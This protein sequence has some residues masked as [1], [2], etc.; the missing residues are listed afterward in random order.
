MDSRMILKERI[1]LR[2][3]LAEGPPEHWNDFL[4]ARYQGGKKKVTNTNPKTKDRYKQVTMQ[5]LFNSDEAFKKKV[6]EEYETWVGNGVGKKKNTSKSNAFNTPSVLGTLEELNLFYAEYG[7]LFDEEFNLSG[8]KSEVSDGGMKNLRW[9]DTDRSLAEQAHAVGKAFLR[10]FPKKAPDL[11][12]FV[13]EWQEEATTTFKKNVINWIDHGGNNITPSMASSLKLQ[14]L[15]AQA[16][17]KFHDIT[18]VT[19]YRGVRGQLGNDTKLG[20]DVN[21]DTK[22]LSSWSANPEVATNFAGG[23]HVVEARVPVEQIF[24]CPPHP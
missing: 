22:A 6:M 21:L 23:G 10:L 16:W 7:E 20:D 4:K 17:F 5:T 14:Y 11:N 18:H 9:N 1:A 13:E 24:M 2:Y 3:L 12:D 15:F 19:L 8:K